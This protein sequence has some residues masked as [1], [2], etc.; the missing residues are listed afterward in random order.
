VTGLTVLLVVLGV[1][2]IVALYAFGVRRLLG[3]RLSLPRALIGG[4][5]ALACASPIITAIGGSI[6]KHNGKWPFLPALWFVIGVA[7]PPTS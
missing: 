6:A 4:V 7:M 2:L 1:V 5:I 3:L